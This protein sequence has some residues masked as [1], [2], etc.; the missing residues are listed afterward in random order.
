MNIIRCPLKALKEN[1]S[2]RF[3]IAIE[4]HKVKVIMNPKHTIEPQ[5]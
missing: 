2:T 5:G 1:F 4:K 3:Y